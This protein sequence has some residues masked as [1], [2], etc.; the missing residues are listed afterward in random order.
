MKISLKPLFFLA[1]VFRIFFLK[2]QIFKKWSLQIEM[3]TLTNL[4]RRD[5]KGLIPNLN[6]LYFEMTVLIPISRQKFKGEHLTTSSKLSI[7]IK[8][9]TFLVY[10]TQNSLSCNFYLLPGVG[11][12]TFR[13]SFGAS[14]FNSKKWS[15]LP[16]SSLSHFNGNTYRLLIQR[17]FKNYFFST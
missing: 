8:G 16:L 11:K 6:I 17:W 1:K 15:D 4:R 5:L 2:K 7:F 12:I 9:R 14:N 13:T 10:I 3:I